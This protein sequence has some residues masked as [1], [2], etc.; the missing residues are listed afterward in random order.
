MLSHVLINNVRN[1]TNVSHLKTYVES[2]EWNQHFPK[3]KFPNVSSDT[4]Y[5]IA[6]LHLDK[7]L[8]VFDFLRS[9]LSVIQP[10]DVSAG[11]V[12][13]YSIYEF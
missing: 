4:Q 8:F 9:F 2:T 6:S 7:G 5:K 3:L 1:D 11:N 10:Y 12:L 13:T